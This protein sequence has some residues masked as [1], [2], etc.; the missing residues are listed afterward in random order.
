MPHT[1]LGCEVDDDL[2]LVFSEDLREGRHVLDPY[3]VDRHGASFVNPA[4]PGLLELRVVVGVEVIQA[5]DGLA[6]NPAVSDQS[7]S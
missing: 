6:P 3:P 7:P 5:D 4:D 1:C 2:R